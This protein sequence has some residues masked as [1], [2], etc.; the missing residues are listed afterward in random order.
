MA[1][2]GL[3]VLLQHMRG[4]AGKRGTDPPP[5]R[6]LL[7]RFARLHD[8][9]A[10]AALV[11]RHGPLVLRVCCRVLPDWQAAEDAFQATFLVS[12]RKAGSI[13]RRERL[14]GWLHGVAYR[15]A[16]RARVEMA[17]RLN[18]ESR[19]EPRTLTDPL[20][21]VS[22]RELRAVLDEE[23]TRL[24]ARYRLPLLLCYVEEQTR[25]Q[26][27]GQLGWSVR[28]LTRRLE[29]GRELLRM[30][31]TR[32]GITAPAAFLVVGLS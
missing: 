10:F 25:D 6:E 29:R 4:W 14:A 32:R 8:E 11:A 30:R 24:P 18:R 19:V 23:L 9:I 26:V 28:T 7:E 21:D 31:L 20:E 16:S 27:A 5:D 15:V 22:A 2:R 17:K 13:T 12:A 3:S 1:D